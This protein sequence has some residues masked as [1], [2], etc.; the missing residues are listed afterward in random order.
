MRSSWVLISLLNFVVASIMGVLLRYVFVAEV[1]WMDYRTMLHGHSHVAML[2]WVYL[3]LFALLIDAFVPRHKKTSSFYNRLFWFTQ[4]TVVGMM[5]SFPIQG[6]GAVS[7]TF[8]SLHIIASYL[9]VWRIW[10]DLVI[11]NKHIFLL[12]R[13]SLL[14]LIISTIG[15]WCMGPVMAL[16]L[17]NDPIYMVVVQFY[18][19]FQF[20]G[21]FA[22]SILALL[23]YQLNQWGLTFTDS[24]FK[25]FFTVYIFS[26]VLT[27]FQVLYWAYLE[28]YMY[29]INAVGVIL[30]VMAFGF[31]LLPVKDKFFQVLTQKSGTVSWLIGF[32]LVSLIIKVAI[33]AAL[34][35]P[36]VTEIST[37]IRQFMIGYIHLTMLGFITGL[38]LLLLYIKEVAVIKTSGIY[39]FSIGY[40]MTEAILFIQ[41]LFFWARWGTLP[42]YH[43]VLLGFSI[44]LPL[45]LL[46]MA[47][48]PTLSEYS[49]ANNHIKA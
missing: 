20:N 11:E 39:I 49:H 5:I 22:L 12:V 34:V 1:P 29:V 26:L 25:I 44:L 15:I 36:E 32:G 3:I 42:Y 16:Q 4:F 48:K 21:W 46:V 24:H 23:V 45:G 6:Y 41:G 47:I 9:F 17:R 37:T 2:G 43:E 40:I 10:K 30:Q 14:F 35:V 18:L 33:Q 13:A 7:I 27:F 19:H 28:H 8:S 31:L 38:I